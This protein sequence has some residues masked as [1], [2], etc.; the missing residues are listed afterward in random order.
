MKRAL[1]GISKFIGMMFSSLGK[2]IGISGG[3]EMVENQHH[4]D[5]S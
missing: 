4:S 1:V 3:I 2:S 5:E